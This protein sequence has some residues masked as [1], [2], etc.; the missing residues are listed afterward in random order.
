MNRQLSILFTFTAI[1]LLAVSESRGGEAERIRFRDEYPVALRRWQ[2]RFAQAKGSFK[3]VRTPRPNPRGVRPVPTSPDSKV[4]FFVDGGFEKLELESRIN[5]GGA[6]RRSGGIICTGPQMGFVLNRLA[7]PDRYTLVRWGNDSSHRL[8]FD[9]MGGDYLYA[10][11]KFNGQT[12]PEIQSA[13]S[14]KL[15]SVDPMPEDGN[16]RVRMERG[17]PPLPITFVLNPNANWAIRRAELAVGPPVRPDEPTSYPTLRSEI[18]FGDR[19]SISGLPLPHVV[20][21]FLTDHLDAT[22]TFDVIKFEPTPAS[23]FT[24]AHFGLTPPIKDDQVSAGPRASVMSWLI[25]LGLAG[26]AVTLGLYR[27][28]TRPRLTS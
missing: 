21:H 2:D 22:C 11:F 12:I 16:Y 4:S 1:S 13:R 17:V 20:R 8:R 18:D 19:D 23:E 7:N 9:R 14:Y 10:A 25:G 27:F 6:S 3:L 26:L 5:I 28:A 15:L 24:L